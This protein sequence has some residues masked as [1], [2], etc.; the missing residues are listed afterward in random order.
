MFTGLLLIVVAVVLVLFYMQFQQ[1]P[2]N[3]PTAPS[4]E[5][6]YF[7][8]SRY[9]G[10]RS[11]FV[12]RQ[13]ARE[14]VSI[15]YPLT[16]NRTINKT[17]ARAI[18][19]A[20]NDFRYAAANILTFDQPLTETISYQ[21]TH[22]NSSALSIIVNIKQDMHGAHPVSLTHFWTF[23]KKS[24][25]VIGLDTLTERSEKAASEI[26][27]AARNAVKETIKQRQQ[28]ELDLNETITKEALSNPL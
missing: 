7:T 27:A 10:I 22:N 23:D 2:A 8:D 14:K 5:Q 3:R 16:K 1:P 9:A 4:D 28:P 6:Y 24:G 18:N 15:E 21:V 17:I 25:E 11:K 12:T 13:T 19:R 26:V 20:D